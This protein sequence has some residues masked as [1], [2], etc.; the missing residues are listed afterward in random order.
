M[1]TPYSIHYPSFML[2]HVTTKV[3]C[4]SSGNSALWLAVMEE[5]MVHESAVKFATT[6]SNGNLFCAKDSYTAKI[7]IFLV[8]QIV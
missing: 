2:K 5:K 7:V 3:K 8:K 1:A 4:L 6:K